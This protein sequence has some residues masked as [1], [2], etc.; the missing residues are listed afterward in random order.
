MDLILC[1]T[2]PGRP[3]YQPNP[4]NPTTQNPS[5]R[6]PFTYPKHTGT[7]LHQYHHKPSEMC[8]DLGAAFPSFDIIE[9]PVEVR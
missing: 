6:L 8:T 2:R 4:L 5:A 7:M 3:S 9:C 1:L